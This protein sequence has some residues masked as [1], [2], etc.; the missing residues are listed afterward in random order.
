MCADTQTR[1]DFTDPKAV[2]DLRD[3]LAAVIE[4]PEGFSV[5]RQREALDAFFEALEGGYLRAASPDEGGVWRA[6]VL[7]KRSILLSFRVGKLATLPAQPLQFS[8]KDTLFAPALPL[9]AKNIRIVPGGSSVRRG[10]YLGRD[11][12]FM[13]PS[14]ANVGAFIDQGTMVDSHALVGSCA[15]I[16]KRCHLSA[17][18]QIGGVLEPVGLAPV[19][20]E[21]DVFVGGNAGV[22]EG[23]VVRKGAVLGAGTILTRASRVYDLVHE[24]VLAATPDLPLEIPPL[25]VV[26]PGSRPVTSGFGLA[27]GLHAAAPLIVK[28]RDAKTDASTTLEDALR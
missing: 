21:D 4:R 16:G 12:T 2:A 22:Y 25:A 10:V 11:V 7:V 3:L 13:P 27:H 17:G 9:E 5:E 19:V 14:F 28:Y 15:Q 8:D 24:R 23:T 1:T 26:I 18:V 6:D 20:I